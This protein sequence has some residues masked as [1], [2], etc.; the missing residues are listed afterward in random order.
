M[1]IL[2]NSIKYYIMISKQLIPILIATLYFNISNGQI[3]P[4]PNG[5]FNNDVSGWSI[6][7]TNVS[8]SHSVEN[9]LSI[10]LVDIYTEIFLLF[11]PQFY[12]DANKTYKFYYDVRND[13]YDPALGVF[14]QLGAF[15]DI[16]LV[17]SNA[18]NL[19]NLTANMTCQT[20]PGYMGTCNSTEFSVAVSGIYRL[21]FTGQK[22][23]ETEFLLDNVGFDE[24]NNGFINGVINYNT[25]ADNCATSTY[26]PSNVTVKSSFATSGNSYFTNSANNGTYLFAFDETG[27]AITEV[28]SSNLSITPVVYS[29]NFTV[30]G[31]TVNNQ[32]FCVTSTINGYDLGVVVIP[33]SDARPGFNSNY[34]VTYTNYGNT[35]ISGSINLNFDNSKVNYLNANPAVDV[36]TS[37]SLLWNF[38]NLLP[39]E[40]RFIDVSFNINTPPTVNNGDNLPF[41]ANINPTVSDAN[42]SNNSFTLNQT[43]IGSYDPNDATILQGPFITVTQAT[44]DLYFRLR[45][46]NTG[47]AS[48]ININVQTIL[49]NDIDISTFQPLYASH[50]YLTSITNGNV[51][52]FKFD[53]INLSDSTSDEPNSHGWILFKAKPISTFAIGDIIESQANIFFDY[54]LPIITNTATTQIDTPMSIEDQYNQQLIVY[55]NPAKNI[56]FIEGNSATNAIYFIYDLLGKQ[57]KTGNT[58][59]NQINLSDLNQGMYFLKMKNEEKV[60]TVKFVKQ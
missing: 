16:N 28:I 53:D 42:N 48:A 3:V 55:P 30:N 54:N 20:N 47:T 37:N 10:D 12:L 36:S 17:D 44:D 21:K 38:T 26:N 33:T 18:N 7:G 45:F 39:L 50:S 60:S 34:S 59:S 2:S 58:Q 1:T 5:Q 35:Q 11:S 4:V 51:V 15:T 43:T 32:N 22:S 49:D 46:Q 24:I 40:T 57:I 27:I 14:V 25:N 41:I 13:Q 8:V 29:N 56:L 19:P 23:P 9:S 52:N 6:L 31:Q